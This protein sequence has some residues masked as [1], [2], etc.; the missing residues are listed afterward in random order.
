MASLAQKFAKIGSKW[1]KNMG[2]TLFE[3]T[4]ELFNLL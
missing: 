4:F 2:Y 3:D 1:N